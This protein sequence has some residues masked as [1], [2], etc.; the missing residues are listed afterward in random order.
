MD[1]QRQFPSVHWIWGVG[2][3]FVY[4]VHPRIVVKVPMSGEFEREQFH[5]K[6]IEIN[7]IFSENQ[8]CPSIIQCFHVSGNGIFHEYMRGTTPY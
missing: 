4:E 6:K 3:S 5:K 8:S 2:I 7:Q 1:I